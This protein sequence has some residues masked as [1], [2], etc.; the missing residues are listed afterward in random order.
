MTPCRRGRGGD[1]AGRVPHRRGVLAAAGARAA[2]AEKAR[3][4][5]GPRGA[6]AR[7]RA[8]RA[9]RCAPSSSA[10][11]LVG[12]AR[13]ALQLDKQ[14]LAAAAGTPLLPQTALASCPGAQQQF[15]GD[16][17]VPGGGR[18][19]GL[20]LRASAPVRA[21]GCTAAV[22]QRASRLDEA[23]FGRCTIAARRTGCARCFRKTRLRALRLALRE[24]A[25]SLMTVAE[26]LEP[27]REW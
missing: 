3:P 26:A 12:A 16:G 11:G 9:M 25:S 7:A 2:L 22:R 4:A 8:R 17:A 6:G 24:P 20:L 13:A 14:P 19:R 5:A 27:G 10:S 23:Q 1:H 18:R 15:A 21:L